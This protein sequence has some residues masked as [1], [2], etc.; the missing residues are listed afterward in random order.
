MNETSNDGF[1]FDAGVDGF[2]VTPPDESDHWRGLRLGVLT[3]LCA[4]V[5]AL[6]F[7]WWTRRDDGWMFAGL[8]GALGGVITSRSVAH[9]LWR[10]RFEGAEWNNREMLAAMPALAEWTSDGTTPCRYTAGGL[11]VGE[12]VYCR[13][14]APFLWL[15]G[16]IRVDQ[17]PSH[18][19]RWRLSLVLCPLRWRVMLPFRV[20]EGD[21]SAPTG[22][23]LDALD[24]LVAAGGIRAPAG[25][26]LRCERIVRPRA[27]LAPVAPEHLELRLPDGAEG[28]A[29]ARALLRDPRI[30]SP[31]P[32][33]HPYR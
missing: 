16:T 17:G 28:R 15:S 9:I 1:V 27:G 11:S 20:A 32:D 19:E 24:E 8:L 12:K 2:A 5:G 33:L 25:M 14:Q 4:A 7:V 31:V 21:W 10:F 23:R 6:V 30:D 22:A 29:V 3:L 13:E 26:D 18:E